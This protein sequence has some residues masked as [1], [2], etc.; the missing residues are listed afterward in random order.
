MAW[1]KSPG[2]RRLGITAGLALQDHSL[3]RA[4]AWSGTGWGPKDQPIQ[5]S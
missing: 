3:E 1:A 2:K 5:Q 4:L